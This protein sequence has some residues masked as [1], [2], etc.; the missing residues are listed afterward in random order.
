MKGR[1]TFWKESEVITR[2]R[3]FF[4]IKDEG[5]LR[6]MWRGKICFYNAKRIKTADENKT[7]E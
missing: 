2:K 4:L 7:K 3:L 5:G 1:S 6:P